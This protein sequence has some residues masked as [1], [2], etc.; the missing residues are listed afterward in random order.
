MAAGV[1]A[2]REAPLG[3]R[4]APDTGDTPTAIS[5]SQKMDGSRA[6]SSNPFLRLVNG[7]CATQTGVIQWRRG[8]RGGQWEV[9]QPSTPQETDPATNNH[10]KVSAP[11]C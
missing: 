1:G 10:T 3:G 9:L 5:L 6:F 11:R 4:A 8:G 7:T 2:T